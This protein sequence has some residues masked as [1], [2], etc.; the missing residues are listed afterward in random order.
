[1]SSTSREKKWHPEKKGVQTHKFVIDLHLCV[2]IYIVSCG[3]AVPDLHRFL[4]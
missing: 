4:D 2:C 1:M 3:F